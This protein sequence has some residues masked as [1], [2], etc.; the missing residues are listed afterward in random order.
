MKYVLSFFLIATCASY[1]SAQSKFNP[2]LKKQLDSVMRLDQKY[3]D[4]LDLLMGQKADSTAISL[5]FAN[6]RKANDHY[7]NLQNHTDSLNLVFIESVFKKYGYPGR[8]LVDTP[9]NK[10][11]WYIIQHSPK[12]SQYIGVM[13]K[14]A[15]VGE[16]PFHLY[17]MMLDRDLM[18]QG[19]EQIYGTQ[20]SC[21]RFKKIKDEWYCMAHQGPGRCK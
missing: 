6:A 4:T 9:A 7:W 13:E 17:A 3:R 20:V 2:H 5:H 8:S 10:D 21:R 14:A 16:L 12:I 15:E 18:N 19:K 1:A 11:A